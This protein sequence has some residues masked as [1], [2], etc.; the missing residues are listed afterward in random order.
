MKEGALLVESGPF[1][2]FSFKIYRLEYTKEERK[3]IPYPGL[4]KFLDRYNLK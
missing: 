2:D 4:V 3:D 1:E